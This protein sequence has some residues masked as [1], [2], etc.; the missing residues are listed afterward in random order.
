QVWS[1]ARAHSAKVPDLPPGDDTCRQEH[2]KSILNIHRR[3]MIEIPVPIQTGG[4]AML[5]E[6]L[7]ESTGKRIVRRV[8]STEPPKVEVSFEDSGKMLGTD[9]TGFGTYSSVVRSDGSIYGEG[10]GVNVTNDGE[11]IT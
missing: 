1:G 4:N 3:A 2:G 10:E 5:G 6:L 9:I 11:M 7:G 8:L